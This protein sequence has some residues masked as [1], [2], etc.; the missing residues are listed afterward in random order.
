M[1]DPWG[2][3][4]CAT[5]APIVLDAGARRF[6]SALAYYAALGIERVR[7]VAEAE[8]AEALREADRLKDALLASVSHDLRTP[9]TTIKALAHDIAGDGDERAATIEQQADGSIAWSQ[10][11]SISRD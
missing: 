3:S 6:L 1:R 9:L 5:T 10:T 7:L 8:R 11:C 4:R 2:C